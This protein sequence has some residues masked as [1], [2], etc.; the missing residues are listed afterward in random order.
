[1][2]RREQS[3]R[4]ERDRDHGDGEQEAHERRPS[5]PSTRHG[6]ARTSNVP[7]ADRPQTSGEDM[8][9]TRGGGTTERPIDVARARYRKW[10]MPGGRSSTNVR[11]RSS[12]ISRWARA[13]RKAAPI[14][15]SA[16]GRSVFFLSFGSGPFA[17]W[18]ARD[19]DAVSS[20]VSMGSS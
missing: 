17:S 20:V 12:C 8:A 18:T 5:A 14:P 2:E 10:Y 4:E 9:A 19:F 11:T 1:R 7:A 16:S 15:V 6:L 3:G 13:S